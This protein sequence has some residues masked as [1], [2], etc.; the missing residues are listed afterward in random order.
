MPGFSDYDLWKLRSPDDERGY[1]DEDEEEPEPDYAERA[2]L[3]HI[4][5]SAA[6][7]W[8]AQ[9]EMDAAFGPSDPNYVPF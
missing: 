4:R 9:A 1:W 6:K 2:E 7:E 3:E 8:A 5:A